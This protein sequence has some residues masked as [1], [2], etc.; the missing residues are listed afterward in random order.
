MVLM[1]LWN[2][3]NLATV[4]LQYTCCM[5]IGFECVEFTEYSKSLIA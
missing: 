4:D 3:I 1:F 5:A 2:L